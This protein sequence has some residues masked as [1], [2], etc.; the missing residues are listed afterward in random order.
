MKYGFWIQIRVRA[1]LITVWCRIFTVDGDASGLSQAAWMHVSPAGSRRGKWPSSPNSSLLSPTQFSLNTPCKVVTIG[2][3]TSTLRSAL[4]T[5][6]SASPSQL[7]TTQWPPT[8]ASRPSMTTSLRWS[9]SLSRP[10]LRHAP[11]WKNTTLHPAWRICRTVLR[12]TFL[13]PFASSSTRTRRPARACADSAPARRAPRTPSFHRKVSKCTECRAAP[14]R[15]SST[16][17]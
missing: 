3:R 15:S 11:G 5:W 9:R 4:C 12:P 17:K 14:M 6:S 8:K 10:M 2:P 7:S 1:R 16:S 13:A